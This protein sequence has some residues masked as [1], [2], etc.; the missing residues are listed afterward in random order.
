MQKAAAASREQRVTVSRLPIGL[1]GVKLDYPL[2]CI[3]L[4]VNESLFHPMSEGPRTVDS[5]KHEIEELRA[6]NKYILN[7]LKVY[8]EIDS[9]G[10]SGGPGKFREHFTLKSIDANSAKISQ[11]EEELAKLR[12]RERVLTVS[13]L[14]C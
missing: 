7:E 12:A 2:T 14:S 8:S 9:K 10:K 11:L 1:R 3:S 5:V 6:T 4:L 13:W